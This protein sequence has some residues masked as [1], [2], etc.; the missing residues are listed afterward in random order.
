[1]IGSNAFKYQNIEVL[2]Y[3]TII[4]SITCVIIATLVFMMLKKNMIID[5]RQYYFI[6][7]ITSFV[8][9]LY[10]FAILYIVYRSTYLTSTT[11]NSIVVFESILELIG[12]VSSNPLAFLFAL[13]M[14]F[15][16]LFGIFLLNLCSIYLA[17]LARAL[18]Q[19]RTGGRH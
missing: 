4:H 9:V 8:T 7:G 16:L 1:M 17:D 18:E 10:F 15:V 6:L 12:S 3:F 13:M 19:K 14:N 11:Y 2:H 5:R